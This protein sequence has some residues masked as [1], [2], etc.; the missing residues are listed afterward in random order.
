MAAL[1][2]A[3]QAAWLLG[4]VAWL[5][6]AAFGAWWE[7]GFDRWYYKDDWRA[8]FLSGART[9]EKVVVV[10]GEVES[11][12]VEVWA[13]NEY[14]LHVNLEPVG[15]DSDGGTIE[16]YDLTGLL[17]AG[18]NEF[19]LEG[20]PEV[21]LDGGA[22]L[23][24]GSVFPIRAEADWAA[25]AKAGRER[26]TGPRG[27][28]G[29]AHQAV[30]LHYSP[31]QRAKAA[32]SE[33]HSL[34][35]RLRDRDTFRFWR[36]RDVAEVLRLEG[37][38]WDLLAKVVAEAN[39]ATSAARSAHPAAARGDWTEVRRLLE[40]PRSV[41]RRL[42]AT[43]ADFERAIALRSLGGDVAALRRQLRLLARIGRRVEP[44][45]APRL[46]AIAAD[47]ARAREPQMPPP[48]VASMAARIEN[49][50]A[51]LRAEIEGRLDL[52]LDSLNRSTANRLGWIISHT[53]LDN[54]PRTWEFSFAPPS[55][56]LLDLAGLWRFRLDPRNEGTTQGFARAD[57]DDAAWARIVAPHEGGWERLG[58]DADNALARGQNNKPYNGHAW[59]R[60]RV[61]IPETWRGRDLE[62]DLGV[63]DD[64]NRD[65]L[66]VNGEPVGDEAA[67]A[68]GSA[69][70]RFTIA[71]A[72]LRPGTTN[73]LAVRVF[74][75]GNRGGLLGPRLRLYPAGAR[76][77]TLRTVCQAGIVQMQTF[78]P[79]S[80]QVAY[81]GALL[82]A[83]LVA[84]T[85]R[86]FRVGGWE[87]KGWPA[88]AFIGFLGADGAQ[89]IEPA[90]E[91]FAL[92][93]NALGGGWL[94]LAPDSAQAKATS[95]PQ[96]LLVL[97]QR[98][99]TQ[100]RWERDPFGASS[101]ILD[102]AT[103]PGIVG[104][105]R[106]F[107]PVVPL[108]KDPQGRAV[109]NPMTDSIGNRWYRFARD[110]PTAWAEL[111]TEQQG[112]TFV[113]M[114][115]EYLETDGDWPFEPEPPAPVP[116]LFMY[117]REHGWPGA[118]AEIIARISRGAA[119]TADPSATYTGLAMAR[120]GIDEVA[121]AY[122]PR[123][124]R[125]HWKGVGT[126]AEIR[127]MDDEDFALL[128]SWGA[129]A[130]RASI[131]FHA[132][133]FAKGFF[134]PGA[135]G[136]RGGL[137]G[138]L[139]WAPDAV[140]WLDRIVERH[141]RHGLTCVINWFWNADNP[142]GEINGAPP[143]ST[144]YWRAHPEARRLILDFW[145]KVAEHY[146]GLPRDA[147]AY[148]L[149]NEPAT[150]EVGAYNEFIRDATAAIRA[151]DT[152]HTIF[153]ESANGWAQPEDF[154]RLQATGD[155]NTVYEFH[156]YGP[157]AF[158]VYSRNIWFPR[159]EHDREAFV[160][161]ES[162][163]ERLLA[164]L[165]F[166]IRNGGAGLCH[167]E[168][169]ITFL[170]PGDSPR[171]WLEALLALHEKYRTHWFWWEYSGRSIHRTGLVAGERWNPLVRTLSEF[172][173]R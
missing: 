82:P 38:D 68:K 18:R 6:P 84:Q 103:S 122:G 22:V 138:R 7:V 8:P 54:D 44:S 97:L 161:E 34:A 91:G 56:E 11:A 24:D 12:W 26:R 166:S 33:M 114:G 27:Y 85:E 162:L 150:L 112:K 141:Q 62:L 113:Q 157:H 23:R 51:A 21:I 16:C 36:V 61:F 107:G 70:G 19:R 126:F 2:R 108:T 156:F 92:E 109:L 31:E 158:D 78:G 28:L 71:A 63:R 133:W 105:L 136:K 145:A 29:D 131:A 98:R 59:Y 152:T 86:R 137:Q 43:A 149:L 110:Y 130:E 128:R 170:G 72:A 164:P 168:L 49:E 25:N 52:R 146:A 153:I 134:E 48:L 129:N 30:I 171:Q 35:G 151:H 87:S 159:Y 74:N 139:L 120:I 142:L 13:A 163:E 65:W 45:W 115:Y 111:V 121:Y 135:E 60:Q 99:P 147:V 160:S 117:A 83:V 132:D 67:R 81:C 1:R 165:R 39:E 94:L 154:D 167:G 10:P 53:P 106:P 90:R 77:E 75:D 172:M 15:H 80:R 69:A 93:G 101:L 37:P 9:Y 58:Y 119:V 64:H 17:H 4:L 116:P 14:T 20:G 89:R 123:E 118:D 96:V 102:Y 104:L 46:E 125:V 40:A 79:A 50:L 57:F 76:P 5:A 155:A 73:S 42:A 140:A 88:P 95:A 127:D 143:N 3:V 32:L 66:F 173:R 41:V 148:D 100:V 169:G 124:P 47:F 144:R 55:A